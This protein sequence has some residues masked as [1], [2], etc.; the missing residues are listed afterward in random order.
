[1]KRMSLEGGNT[2]IN[3]SKSTPDYNAANKEV[4]FLLPNLEGFT[5]YDIKQKEQ[6][7]GK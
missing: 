2:L 3:Y 1:M 4:G 5:W 7:E 6:D